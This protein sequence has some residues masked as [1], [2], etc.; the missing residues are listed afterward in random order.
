MSEKQKVNYAIFAGDSIPATGEFLI[1]E[2]GFDEAVR[3]AK[4]LFQ[5]FDCVQICEND[6][7][8]VAYGNK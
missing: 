1:E 6:K 4:K 7:L 2:T 8:L 5:K 3:K